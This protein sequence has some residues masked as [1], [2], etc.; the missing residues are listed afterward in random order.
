MD[1]NRLTTN[2]NPLTLDE[3]TKS[4][5]DALIKTEPLISIDSEGRAMVISEKNISDLH[6]L[7]KLLI[8]MVLVI[9]LLT[10]SLVLKL[11]M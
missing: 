4:E 5:L 2:S 9:I 1:N 8:W 11:F 7:L 3:V 6:T 10:E